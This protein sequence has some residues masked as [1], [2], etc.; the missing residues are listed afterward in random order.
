MPEPTLTIVEFVSL[1]DRI[2]PTG[3]MAHSK[4]NK[5]ITDA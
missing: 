1:A 3:I 5:R 2:I 4:E